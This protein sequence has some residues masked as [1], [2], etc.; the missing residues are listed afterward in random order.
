MRITVYTFPI[1]KS[2]NLRVSFPRKTF[3][4]LKCIFTEFERFCLN[5]PLKKVQRSCEAKTTCFKQGLY[6]VHSECDHSLWS[7]CIV[8]KGCDYIGV[9]VEEEMFCRCLIFVWGLIK[10][11]H[12]NAV[13]CIFKMV[14]WKW[15][16]IYRSRT[17]LNLTHCSLN[18]LWS[19]LTLQMN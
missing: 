15:T 18:L 3:V 4:F 8:H 2:F 13:V 6:F 10:P 19:Q 7:P 17:N 5:L 12:M 1:Y 11:E 16:Q 14:Q 9:T